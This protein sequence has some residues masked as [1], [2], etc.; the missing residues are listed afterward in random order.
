MADGSREITEPLI[1]K[2]GIFRARELA[3]AGLH[4]EIL[5]RMVQKGT[6]ERVGRGLYALPDH[7]ITEHYSLKLAAKAAPSAVICLLSALRYHEIGTQN[8]HQVWIALKYGASAPRPDYVP[9][10]IAHF[11]ASSFEA[12]CELHTVD[13]VPIRIYSPAKTVA[14]CFKFRNLVGLDVALEALKACLLKQRCP[15]DEI[16]QYAAICRVSRVMLPYVE[17]LV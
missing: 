4:P 12:G 9:L 8:P 1:R 14:D 5:R 17:A 16:L 11:S 13:G 7:D 3:A 6:I 15:V 10:R 2:G